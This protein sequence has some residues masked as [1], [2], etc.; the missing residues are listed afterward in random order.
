MTAPDRRT[1]EALDRL[2]AQRL[3]ER[4]DEARQADLAALREVPTRTRQAL[5]SYARALDAAYKIDRDREG[6]GAVERAFAGARA[7]LDARLGELAQ[8][9]ESAPG[10][11][12]E[13]ADSRASRPGTDEQ[14]LAELRESRAWDRTRSRLAGGRR[15]DDL[16]AEALGSGDAT[17]LRALVAELPAWVEGVDEETALRAGVLGVEDAAGHVDAA[18]RALVDV[19]PADQA[20]TAA[21]RLS[22]RDAEA[23]AAGTLD[24]ARRS[25]AALIPRNDPA[26]AA[27][28]P[29]PT[30]AL[31]RH[32]GV[33]D[34]ETRAVFGQDV[35]AAR[36]VNDR[37]EP[38]ALGSTG[39]NSGDGS[40]AA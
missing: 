2:H 22:V 32:L 21:V 30:D 33:L 29:D 5:D 23:D 36:R 20:R 6:T 19:L 15:A 7:E 12:R 1:V 17:T 26:A 8:L 28:D 3:A 14:L 37:D 35:L 39:D 18:E 38:V 13:W 16:I 10:R 9:A 25:A 40:S 11:V 24:G 31:N 34:V 4:A 27:A